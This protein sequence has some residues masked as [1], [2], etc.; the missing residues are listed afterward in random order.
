[1]AEDYHI[2]LNFLPI[3]GDLP[4]FN[5]YRKIRSDQQEAKPSGNDIH[6]YTLP[7][8]EANLENRAQYW[9][10][11][12]A[13]AGFESFRFKSSYNNDL[14][15]WALFR[16]IGNQ[17]KGRIESADYWISSGHLDHPAWRETHFAI[18]QSKQH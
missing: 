10:A 8:T 5:I 11:F 16:A 13:T 15:T 9:V 3:I 17:C 14:I 1:M 4:D 18:L 7:L 2:H 6:G 12:E